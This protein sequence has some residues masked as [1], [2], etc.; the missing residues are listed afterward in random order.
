MKRIKYGENDGVQGI[1][2]DGNPQLEP[3]IP[4]YRY[5]PLRDPS[6]TV[7]LVN[8][9]PTTGDG[10]IALTLRDSVLAEAE[11]HYAAISYTWGPSMRCAKF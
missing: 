4:G 10:T 7:R 6:S 1:P 9:L 2:H 3:L 11:D 5:K 8:I